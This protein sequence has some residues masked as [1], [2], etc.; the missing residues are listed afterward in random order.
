MV[1]SVR[2]KFGEGV[3][4]PAV[5]VERRD[6]QRIIITFLPY[7]EVPTVLPAVYGRFRDTLG[8]PDEAIQG[9]E[10]EEVIITFVEE[11]LNHPLL[12]DEEREAEWKAFEELIDRCAVDT[13]IPDLAHQHDHYLHGTPKKED[14]YLHDTPTREDPHS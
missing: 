12:S 14:P 10:G 5:A 13:G 4:R 8:K 6:G 7:G 11:R 3:A 2:G 9:H 1:Q